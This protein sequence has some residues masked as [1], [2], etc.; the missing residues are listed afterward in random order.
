CY[1]TYL[2]IVALIFFATGYIAQKHLAP[3]KKTS[4]YFLVFLSITVVTIT[5]LLLVDFF[6]PLYI[7]NAVWFQI[8]V[9]TVNFINKAGYSALSLHVIESIIRIVSAIFC[10]CLFT[11]GLLPKQV[12]ET[13]DKGTVHLS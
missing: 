6:F 13:R 8:A 11:I 4:L 9:Q 5:L 3:P 12:K 1:I 10:L 7:I 2:F